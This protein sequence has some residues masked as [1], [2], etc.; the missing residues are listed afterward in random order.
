[1]VVV[2]GDD[3]TALC[4]R[5]DDLR[6]IGMALV[7]AQLPGAHVLVHLGSAVRTLDPDEARLICAALDG[8]QAAQRG[9]DF[10][11]LF[12][13]LIGRAPELPPHLR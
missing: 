1:M 8:L 2:D 7:G 6:R 4:R 9:E 12:A 5:G 10:E 11:H 3:I 13:D